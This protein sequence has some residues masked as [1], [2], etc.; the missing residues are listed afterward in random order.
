VFNRNYY[1]NVYICVIVIAAAAAVVVI[2]VYL[3]VSVPHHDLA[4]NPY[5]AA[6]ETQECG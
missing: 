2:V 4:G 3:Y 1:R 5:F 6:P